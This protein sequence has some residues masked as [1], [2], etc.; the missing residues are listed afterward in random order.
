ML[1]GF[2]MMI[3]TGISWGGVGVVVSACSR[4]STSYKTV[5]FFIALQMMLICVVSFFILPP[6]INSQLTLWLVL[7]IGVAAGIGNYFTFVLTEKAMKIGPNGLIWS[8]MQSSL[9]GTFIMGILF[10]GERASLIRYC[11]LIAIIAGV[12]F[13]GMGK[14]N[15]TGKPDGRNKSWLWIALAAMLVA[16]LTQCLNTLPSFLPEAAGLGVF[17]RS[18]SV[19]LGTAVIFAATSMAGAI[20]EHKFFNFWTL[21]MSWWGILISCISSFLCFYR[22]LDVLAKYGCGG[23]GYPVAIGVCIVAFAAYS[24]T[25]LKEKFSRLELTGLTLIVL[26]ITGISFG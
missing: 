5:Q 1:W 18:F 23:S 12:I 3:I 6:Q 17:F 4:R 22:G 10:F 7:L 11:G 2:I 13:S 20:R 21:V 8:I 14:G 26:G 16:M 9:C 24:M 15:D 25:V 19:Q